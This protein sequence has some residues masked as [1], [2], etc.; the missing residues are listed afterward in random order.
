MNVIF[1]TLPVCVHTCANKKWDFVIF[2]L[3]M[4]FIDPS[5]FLLSFIEVISVIDIQ[6]CI[7][8]RCIAY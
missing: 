8:L 5:V 1:F 3:L 2:E 6:H 7:N 4:C